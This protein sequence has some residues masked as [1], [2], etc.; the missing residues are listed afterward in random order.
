MM[1]IQVTWLSR[2]SWFKIKTENTLIH[3]DPG[4]TGYFKN[5]GVPVEELKDKANLIF[6]THPHKDHLQPE[7]LELI[8]GEET[9]IFAPQACVER[10]DRPVNVVKPGDAFEAGG[11]KVKTVPAYNTPEGRSTR[12]VHHKGN[13]V[14][15]LI[16][17]EGKTIYHAGD[18]DFIPEMAQLGEVDLALLPIG[19]TFVMD[20]D[21]AAE[22]ALAIQPR[23]AIPMHRSSVDPAAFQAQVEARSSVKVLPLS[24][25]EVFHLD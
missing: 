5:Q 2:A 13:F 25:G 24:L 10:I 3:I 11:I 9:R 23:F 12:K 4:Y 8:C 1:S 17:V 6:I 16:A 7:A 18:T 15:Y 22:A 21:E 19:G 20:V 14:G